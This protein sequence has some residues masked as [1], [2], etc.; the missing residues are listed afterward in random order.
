MIRKIKVLNMYS[1]LDVGLNIIIVIHREEQME[2]AEYI[3][4]RAH[5]CW[6][7]LGKDLKYQGDFCDYL[8]SQLKQSYI[9]YE[10]YVKVGSSL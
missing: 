4:N 6:Y 1:D 10:L 9:E 7:E 3:M 2:Q 5:E 8:E